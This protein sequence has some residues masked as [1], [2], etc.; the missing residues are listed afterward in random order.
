MS[1]DEDLHSTTE[2]EDKVEGGLLLDVIVRKSASILKLFSSEDQTLLIGRDSFFVLDLGLHIGNGVRGLHIQGD[3]LARQGLHEDLHATTEAEDEVKSG[4]LLDVIVREGA[5]ILELL[6]G[7]NQSLLIRRDSFLV[8][9]LGLHVGDGVRRL[10]IQ[11]DDLARQSLHEDLH[12]TTEAED[13]MESGLL[14]DVVIRKSASILEL[15]SGEDQ[16]LLIGGNSFLVLDLGFH[17][18]DGIRR[19]HIQG[20]GL[21]REGLH[22]YLHSTAEA[23]DEMKGRLLLDVVVRQGAAVLKLFSGENQSLL[24]GWDSFLVLDLGLHVGDGVRGL[25]IQGDGLASQGLHEDLH[26]STQAE[27]KVEGGLLL[28]VV[29]RQ[30]SAIFELFSGEDESLLVRRNA[31]LVLDLGLHVGNSVRRLHIQGDGF[32]RQGLHEDLHAT[33]KAEDKVEGGLLLDVIVRKGA[34]ILKLLSSEDQSLLIRGDAFL[35][36]D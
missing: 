21:A 12:A 33:T 25:H 23:E 5:P 32:T 13:E 11:G 36:L 16:S 28:D 29:V 8:L 34:S 9:D 19:L 24:I 26:S 1:L 2:A 22:E 10:H 4:L 14:L 3:G 20:D 15:L 6:S 18:G 7:E 35:V 30:G 31:L 17:I 27:N